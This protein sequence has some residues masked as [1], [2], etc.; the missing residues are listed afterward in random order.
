M[1]VF[2]GLVVG[3][4]AILGHAGLPSDPAADAVRRAAGLPVY[5]PTDPKLI[6]QRAYLA[7]AAERGP[8]TQ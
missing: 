1:D 6:D 5:C 7:F 8:N 4:D 3:E 2:P